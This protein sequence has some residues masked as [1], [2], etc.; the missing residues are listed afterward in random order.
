VRDFRDSLTVACPPPLPAIGR[1][2]LPLLLIEVP[3]RHTGRVIGKVVLLDGTVLTALDARFSSSREVSGTM[4]YEQLVGVCRSGV[5]RWT[6]RK[7]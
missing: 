7:T 3:I 6:A 5:V 1:R 4:R 2:N